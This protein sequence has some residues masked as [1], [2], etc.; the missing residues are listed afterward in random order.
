MENNKPVNHYYGDSV[1]T[2]FIITGVALI[3][4][5]PFFYG[6]VKVSINIS[7]IGILIL[8]ILAGLLNPIQKWII[9]VN[10]LVSA[11]AFIFFEYSALFA[12]INLPPI[13]LSNILF[14]WVNQVLSVLM[15]LAVYLSTKTLRGMWIDERESNKI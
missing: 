13:E 10:S 11:A 8:S 1:R 2:I 4:G 12:Y 15:F 3:A 9:V 14:F 7:I 6:L 5:L